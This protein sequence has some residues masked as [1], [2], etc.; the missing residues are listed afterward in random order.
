[1]S[2]MSSGR[3]K[4]FSGPVTVFHDLRLPEAA[5]LAGYAALIDAYGLAVPV[6]RTLAA[7]GPS[8]KGYAARNWRIFPLHHRPADAF[9]AHLTFALRYEGLD[10]G[11]LKALFR[12]AGPA[13]VADMARA[14][15]ACPYARRIWFLYEWLLGERLDLPDATQGAFVPVVD[16]QQ[17]WAISGVKST[18]CRVIDNLP[19]APAFCPL[20]FRTPALEAFVARDLA[21]EARRVVG[22]APAGLLSQI[23]SSLLLAESRSSFQFDGAAPAPD[24]VQRWAGVIGE[25]GR[26]P[27]DLDELL[28]LKRLVG[29]DAGCCEDSPGLLE[30]LAVFDKK[31][32]R[33]FDPVITVAA[34]AFGLS[35]MGPMAGGAGRLQCYLIHHVLA[36]RGFTPP[37]VVLPVSAV[38]RDRIDDYRRALEVCSRGLRPQN[39]AAD[40]HRFFDATPLAEFLYA[41][42]ARTI[43]VDLPK[44]IRTI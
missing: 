15:P 17:Q 44:A 37:G 42:V 20:A 7:I 2:F 32:G 25:A 29:G 10:L 33:E 13:P 21:E 24:R 3:W 6:P 40:F 36:E 27:I 28:R 16:P 34:L 38:I 22:Q 39:G 30:E 4:P 5:A 43:D 1:L 14:A 9:G 18:R 19:G 23:A 11:V 35:S 31:V 41:C 26:R 8:H 12:A